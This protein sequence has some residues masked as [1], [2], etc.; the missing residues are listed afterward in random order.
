MLATATQ[1]YDIWPTS[2]GTNSTAAHTGK[3]RNMW[4]YVILHR[5]WVGLFGV[6]SLL[7]Q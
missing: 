5:N 3:Y 1:G 2:Q 4:P 6:Q 7:A